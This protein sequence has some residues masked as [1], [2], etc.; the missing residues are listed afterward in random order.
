[1][2]RKYSPT[3]PINVLALIT[4]I[5]HCFWLV[6]DVNKSALSFSP[7]N[8]AKKL[9]AFLYFFTAL[10]DIAKFVESGVFQLFPNVFYPNMLLK[11]EI[12]L[13]FIS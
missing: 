9:K 6:K 2:A 11:F 3:L 10:S 13:L 1:M 4:L 8:C 5:C 12:T 7:M